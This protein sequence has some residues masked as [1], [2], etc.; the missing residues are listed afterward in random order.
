MLINHS[1]IYALLK[2]SAGVL[3]LMMILT[4][5][6]L[7]SPEE[8]GIYA[9]LISAMSIIYAIF[10]HWL[11]LSVSRFYG[12]ESTQPSKLLSTIL[13]SFFIAIIVSGLLLL[14]GF[15]SL[16]HYPWAKFCF[17][18]YLLAW[19]YAWFELNL[20]IA[21]ASLAP[22]LYGMLSLTKS[23][24]GLL[25]SVSLYMLMGF[26]GIFI[27][28]VLSALLLPIF[29][30]RKIWATLRFDSLDK[31]LFKKITAYGFPLAITGLLTLVVDVSDRFIIAMIL[32]EEQAGLYSASYD[33]VVQILGFIFIIF[34]LASF[35][36]IVK[37]F[38]VKDYDNAKSAYGQYLVLLFV[39]SVPVLA[40]FA[41]LSRDIAEL[42][43]GIP[44]RE[45]ANQLIPIIAL[46][47]FVGSFKIHFFDLVFQLG[48][49]TLSQIFPA[50]ITALINI[51]L[52]VSWIPAY[53][54]VGAAYATLSAFIIGLIVSAI[55]AGRILSVPRIAV[56]LLKVV[57][58]GTAMYQLFLLLSPL[59]AWYVL[60]FKVIIG[61][62]LYAILLFTL[63][64]ADAK[65][66]ILR[67]FF[68]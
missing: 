36:I 31:K 38:S 59:K 33:F 20:R 62:L 9:M 29:W 42:L 48:N 6:R 14:L 8:Y 66:L 34:Y 41:G 18:L 11:S 10:F 15:I 23:G 22:K 61:L 53:G 13:F 43:F 21:N 28:I 39:S 58:A 1:L 16:K 7:L 40:I 60:P 64:V 2:G 17:I 67:Y 30:M 49:K 32:G 50:L 3:S 4:F 54:I 19:S 35:P 46:G 26:N 57:A 52:N 37:S 65:K 27:G 51:L 47:M 5:T 12:V 55:M 44:F 24:L 25:A 56:D 63:N 45:S 68:R